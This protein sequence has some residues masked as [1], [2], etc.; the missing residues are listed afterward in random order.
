MQGNVCRIGLL[1][2]QPEGIP[3]PLGDSIYWSRPLVSL[4]FGVAARHRLHF[5][6]H[7]WPGLVAKRATAIYRQLRANHEI[8]H[9]PR[10]VTHTG[11][12]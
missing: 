3:T 4:I 9:F 8:N 2:C 6:K 5:W 12:P 7:A 11:I 1:G 10:N